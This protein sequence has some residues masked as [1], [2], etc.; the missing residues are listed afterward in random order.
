[1]HLSANDH[2]GLAAS[3][4][5]FFIYSRLLLAIVCGSGVSSNTLTDYAQ[6]LF[7]TLARA[8]LRLDFDAATRGMATI[9][10]R[11]TVLTDLG[12]V[13]TLHTSGS[14]ATTRRFSSIRP[15]KRFG[16]AFR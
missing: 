6:F 14:S 7:P 5:H 1:M 9:N 4:R 3:A 13:N 10:A 8:E 12:V 2:R 11:R 15:A 16:R